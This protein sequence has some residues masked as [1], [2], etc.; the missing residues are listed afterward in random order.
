MIG[1]NIVKPIYDK[2]PLM[3]GWNTDE[4]KVCINR[5]QQSSNDVMG[6]DNDAIVLLLGTTH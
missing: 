5:T 1:W 3:I 4:P 6:L 2:R